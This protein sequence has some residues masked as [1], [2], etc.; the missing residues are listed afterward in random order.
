MSTPKLAAVMAVIVAVGVFTYFMLITP[1]MGREVI[2]Q[3]YRPP[4]QDQQ[5]PDNKQQPMQKSNV[6]PAT[7]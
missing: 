1:R 6:P 7:K 3:G 2:D 5:P 4:I